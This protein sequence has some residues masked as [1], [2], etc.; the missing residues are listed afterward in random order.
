[1]VALPPLLAWNQPGSR[2]G[3]PATIVLP[4]PAALPEEEGKPAWGRHCVSNLRPLQDALPSHAPLFSLFPAVPT[5]LARLQWA[6]APQAPR[7][8]HR[9]LPPL[10][11]PG[12][13]P[14][15][16]L[17]VRVPLEGRAM[18]PPPRPGAGSGS[19]LCSQNKQAW[20]ARWQ[21]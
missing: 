7:P 21:L 12:S 9:L 5:F 18:P 19:E 3:Q 13:L 14:Q 20:G 17:S 16:L 15:P 8:G 10:P 2:P 4:S 11:C 1:M 6:A